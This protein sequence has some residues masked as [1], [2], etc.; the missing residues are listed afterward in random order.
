V[1]NRTY[2]SEELFDIMREQEQNISRAS[3]YRRLKQSVADRELIPVMRG[4]Y[5]VAN[6]QVY[7]YE[8]SDKAK[9]IKQK[10]ELQFP[11]VEFAIFESLQL[12]EFINHQIA[13][14]TIFV[15]VDKD[16]LPFVFDSLKESIL[17]GVLL[18]P[19]VQLF[20]QYWREDI[21][22]LTRLLTE[23]PIKDNYCKLEK[24]LVDLFCDNVQR[25]LFS[26]S[27]LPNLLENAFDKYQIDLS[28]FTRY[29]K[30]R[31][32]YEKIITFINGNTH[33][34]LKV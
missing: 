29:A 15:Q 11:A 1:T 31:G 30:R 4:K 9:D 22:V 16:A 10:I 25:E 6:K 17:G 18:N 34:E 26:Q 33:I 27:E 2:T 13:R 14:N 21:I 28:C 5:Q 24:I 8:L 7:S 3:F 12:N 20:N 23:A 32:A 19:S